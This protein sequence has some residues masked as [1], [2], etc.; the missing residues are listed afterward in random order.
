MTPKRPISELIG[1]TQPQHLLTVA[2]AQSLFAPIGASALDNVKQS[3]LD[4]ALTILNSMLGQKAAL[5]HGHAIAEIS[6][7]QTALNGKQPLGNYS[8]VGHDHDYVYAPMSHTQPI[9]SVTGLQDA[10]NDRQPINALLSSIA[11][12][13]TAGNAGK[14]IAVNSAGTAF[15]LASMQSAPATPLVPINTALPAISGTPSTGQTLTVSNGSW[16]NSPTSYAY[17]WKRNG[18]SLVGGQNQTWTVISG[19]EGTALSCTVTATNASG[20]TA[21]TSTSVNATAPAQSG[22]FP[23]TVNSSLPNFRIELATAQT[24]YPPQFNIFDT[25][26]LISG[27]RLW[28]RRTND[29]AGLVSA[30]YYSHLLTDA[31]LNSAQPVTLTFAGLST[32]TSGTY[33]YVP[34]VER[35][36]A[37]STGGLMVTHGPDDVKPVLSDPVVAN[38]T[39]A[40]GTIVGATSNEPGILYVVLTSTNTVPTALQVE[41]AQDSTGAAALGKYQV[42]AANTPATVTITGGTSGATRYVFMMAKDATGNRSDVLPN[43]SVTF[44]ANTSAWSPASVAPSGDAGNYTFSN[45]N[46]KLEQTSP[47]GPVTFTGSQARSSG[48]YWIEYTVNGERYSGPGLIDTVSGVIMNWERNSDDAGPGSPWGSGWQSDEPSVHKL[49]FEVDFDNDTVQA[50]KNG[51]SAG[52]HAFP[53]NFGTTLKPYSYVGYQTGGYVII[54]TGQ[55]VPEGTVSAGFSPWG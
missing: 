45:N 13:L 32:I 46:R 15:E 24:A 25:V 8:V 35:A 41:N 28:L 40:S 44:L 19:D 33:R 20:S 43:G 1:T 14:V 9:G 11:A 47:S 7:L 26:N 48:K 50:F 3:E 16:I 6:G 17:Q 52:T 21:A 49:R 27:D 2:G 38:G 42:V 18:A 55:D 29:D 34:F 5:N 51:I 12:L 10:L 54:N 30:T 22:S 36:G 39:T 31:D 53:A 37:R 4:A 23:T